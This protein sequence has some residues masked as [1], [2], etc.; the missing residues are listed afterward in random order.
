MSTIPADTLVVVADG[1]GARV[2]RN[3]AE[4]R[5]LELRQDA[6]LEGEN[7]NDDGPAGAQP[8]ESDTDEATFAKQLAHQLNQGALKQKYKHLVLIADPGTLGQM[9][10]LLHKETQ[11]RLLQEIPKTLTGMP[12][13]AIE[14]ALS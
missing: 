13:E 12:I 6:V 9:R 2:F 10:P 3:A 7:L 14:K 4:T 11:A 5:K 8:S 1:R